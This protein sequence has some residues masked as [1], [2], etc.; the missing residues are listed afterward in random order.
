VQL[1]HDNAEAAAVN[2]ATAKIVSLWGAGRAAG[3]IQRLAE[4]ASVLGKA[5]G[6][7]H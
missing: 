4:E 1:A 2:D 5:L 6:F 3:W 7:A